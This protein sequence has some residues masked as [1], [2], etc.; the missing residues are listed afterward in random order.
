VWSWLIFDVSQMK[1]HRIAAVIVCLQAIVLPLMIGA[2]GLLPGVI[3]ALLAMLC[4]AVFL[5]KKWALWTALVLMCIQVPVL[6]SPTVSWHVASGAGFSLGVFSGRSVL[7]SRLGMNGF[8]GYV[9]NGAIARPPMKQ[10]LTDGRDLLGAY[11]VN[12]AVLPAAFTLLAAVRKKP[13][14]NQALEP[15]RGAVTPR[16]P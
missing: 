16:A 8:T 5:E 1:P 4:V 9:F 14:A 3:Q 15:T 6:E 10:I 11:L 12:L 7:D 2:R 13:R